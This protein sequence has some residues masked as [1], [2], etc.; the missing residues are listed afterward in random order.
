MDKVKRHEIVTAIAD[1]A[2]D[3]ESASRFRGARIDAD[4][5]FK[6][7]CHY[8]KKIVEDSERLQECPPSQ[9]FGCIRDVALLGLSLAP[10]TALAYLVPRRDNKR[11]IMACTLYTSWRGLKLAAMKWGSLR[12][13]TANV[14]YANEVCRIVL[15]TEPKVHH[16]V[17]L[18]SKER[19]VKI[20]AY[21]CAVM[22]NSERKVEYIDAE[23]IQR[24]RSYSESKDSKFSPWTN[25]PE[26][27]WRKSAVRRGSKH[28]GGSPEFASHME[29]SNRHE[30]LILDAREAGSTDLVTIDQ[31]R[32]IHALLTEAGRSDADKVMARI[33]G[34]MGVEKFELI[35][36]HRIG[37]AKMWAE[38][39]LGGRD[40]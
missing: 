24:I 23:Q 35:A 1:F 27:M 40:G 22:T 28:W 2:K 36:A 32:E 19:G 21:C 38:R 15:G 29:T 16:E 9:V 5:D 33:A 7:Q 18:N 14:V 11:R 37:E 12:D 6:Q 3:R 8:A 26:E 4:L 30:G 39:A 25:F 34:T 13:L 17:V 10:A 20:G 31:T